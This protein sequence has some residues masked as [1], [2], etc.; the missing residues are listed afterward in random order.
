MARCAGWAPGGFSSAHATLFDNAAYVASG[1]ALYRIDLDGTVTFLH[2]YS[3]IGVI[4]FHHNVDR[5][6]VGVI[7]DVNTT[8]A[9]ESVNVELDGAVQVVKIWDLVKIIS[10]AMIAGGDDP[11][12]FVFPQ[13]PDPMDWFHNNATAYNRADDSLVISSRENFVIC[14]DY[15][16]LAIKW[17]LEIRPRSGTNFLPSQDSPSTV[18]RDS[19]PP[20]ANM[21]LHSPTIS[22]CCS[23][24]MGSVACFKHRQ[25]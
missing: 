12:Q 23:S 8:S 7:L 25:E 16:S 20:S 22:I 6:K 18:A 14:L 11:T 4:S 10:D 2:D 19:L 24:I 21:P 5:G 1:T 17:I 3:D 13:Q 15:D 9:M